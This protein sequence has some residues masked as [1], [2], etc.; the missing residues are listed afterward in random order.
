VHPGF[1]VRPAHCLVAIV[2][3]AHPRATPD[4]LVLASA[5]L[6]ARG[7]PGVGA[8]PTAPQQA[9][10]AARCHRKWTLAYTDKRAD[11]AGQTI[12]ASLDPRQRTGFRTCDR[13][14]ASLPSPALLES[15]QWCPLHVGSS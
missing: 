14:V 12:R 15:P 13:G 10:G 3:A 5:R 11:D 9:C 6:P 1:R 8:R 4:E 2:L 7:H